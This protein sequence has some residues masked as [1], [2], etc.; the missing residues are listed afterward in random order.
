MTGRV[1]AAALLVAAIVTLAGCSNVSTEVP[2]PAPTAT[3]ADMAL[4][5]YERYWAVTS[6][7]FAAPSSR[8]WRPDLE[9]V[10]VGPAF[11]AAMQDILSSAALPA[12]VEGAVARAPEVQESTPERV[13][14]VDCI[15]LQDSLLVND[16]TGEVYD[17]IENR[18]P[19]YTFR[20][21]VANIDNIWMVEQIAPALEDPC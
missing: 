21:E 16:L 3:P 17:D 8:D 11:D 18:V 15:D 9:A 13:E 20:A 2:P 14:I 5:A 19:R 12:H 1:E 7:A 10:A 6:S 4:A